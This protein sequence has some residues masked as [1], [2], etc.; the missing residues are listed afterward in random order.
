VPAPAAVEDGTLVG[1]SQPEAQNLTVVI[2]LLLLLCHGKLCRIMILIA[3]LRNLMSMLKRG[4]A[5]HASKW[6]CMLWIDE[7]SRLVERVFAVQRTWNG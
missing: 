6:R 1:I 4:R 7:L 3:V 5:Q 2:L